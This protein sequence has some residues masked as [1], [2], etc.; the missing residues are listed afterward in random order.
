MTAYTMTTLTLH[1]HRLGVLCEAIMKPHPP[2]SGVAICDSGD[3]Y[4]EADVHLATY[5]KVTA[6]GTTSILQ[7]APENGDRTQALFCA[8]CCAPSLVRALSG[9]AHG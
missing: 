4:L 1:I 6:E 2:T 3:D 8:P 7:Y 9:L 5:G